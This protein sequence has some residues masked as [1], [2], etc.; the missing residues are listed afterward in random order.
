MNEK[1]VQHK[2]IEL[3]KTKLDGKNLSFKLE[4]KW[5]T[6]YYQRMFDVVVYKSKDQ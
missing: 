6:N 4:D 1:E 2:L 3:L 5:V